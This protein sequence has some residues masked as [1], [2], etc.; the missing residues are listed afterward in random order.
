MQE[1][2]HICAGQ[3]VL[4][5]A[6]TASHAYSKDCMSPTTGTH[7]LTHKKIHS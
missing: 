4:K 7:L 1:K 5:L 6:V 2:K 3:S